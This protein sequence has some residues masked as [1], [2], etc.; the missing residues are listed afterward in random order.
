MWQR[1]ERF[2]TMVGYARAA[3]ALA[4]MGYHAEAKSIMLQRES[5]KSDR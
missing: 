4:Q 1:F 3:N 5:L 2:V